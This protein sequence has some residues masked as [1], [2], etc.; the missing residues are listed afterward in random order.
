MV[1]QQKKKRRAKESVIRRTRCA[2]RWEEGNDDAESRDAVD[3]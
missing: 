1:L 2:R 3:E